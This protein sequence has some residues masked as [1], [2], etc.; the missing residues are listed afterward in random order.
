[1]RAAM[2]VMAVWVSSISGSVAGQDVL[3]WHNDVARTGQNVR[4]S[5]L[6]PTSVSRKTFGKLFVIAVNGKVDAEPL[7]IQGLQMPNRG[8]RNV[9]FVATEH[10]SVY[11]F[12]ADSGQEFWHVRLLREGETTSDNRN[13]SQITPE[14]GI[15]ATPVIDR[16]QG[17]HGLLYAVA[18]TKDAQGQYRQRLHALDLQ[19]GAEQ[20]GGPVEIR[21]TYADAPPFDPKQY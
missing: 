18:M 4:E 16:Q 3:T 11:A 12:D 14:I 2:L 19:S 6:T 17:P 20:L 13:C 8:A 5:A 15:T 21:A 9:L 7:Y 1:M 10:D